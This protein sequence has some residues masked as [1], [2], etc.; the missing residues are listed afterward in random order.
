MPFFDV[1]TKLRTGMGYLF[2]MQWS[3]IKALLKVIHDFGLL[4]RL[5]SIMFICVLVNCILAQLSMIGAYICSAIKF[6]SVSLLD[7]LHLVE[8]MLDLMPE[9]INQHHSYKHTCTV[10]VCFFVWLVFPL[11]MIDNIGRPW[12]VNNFLTTL[13]V[14]AVSNVNLKSMERRTSVAVETVS[15]CF[16]VEAGSQAYWQEMK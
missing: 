15:D 5:N 13:N 14:S 9:V 10:C 16:K 8:N 3:R 4:Y 1:N 6:L 12:R 11:S 7:L 2:S